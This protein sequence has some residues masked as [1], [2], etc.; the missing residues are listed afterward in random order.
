[1]VSIGCAGILVSDLFCGPMAALP[2]EGE[3]LAV[4]AMTISAGGCAANVAIDLALQGLSVDI[5]GCVGTDPSAAPLLAELERYGVGCG[6]VTRATELPTSKTVILVIEHEDRRYIHTFGANAAFGAGDL[7]ADWL[8]G[9]DIFYLGGLFALPAMDTSALAPLLHAAR[10]AGTRTVVDVVVPN[11]DAAGAALDPLLPQIDIFVPNADEARAFTGLDAPL[12]QIAALQ[13]R[14]AN[15]VIVTCGE[16]G[17]YAGAAGRYFHAPAYGLDTV[18]PSGSGDAFTAGIIAGI[19]QG[20]DLEGM[21]R[22]GAA[23]GAS[24]ARAMGTTT[25]VFR[26]GEAGAFIAANPIDVK[27]LPWKSR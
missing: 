27:E 26:G 1:M 16:G 15:T 21:L 9:L 12:E 14:G 22:L 10:A 18:D 25:S 24:A 8:T 5:A 23:L 7:D 19:A 20:L 11:S 2:R 4:P 3:L 6:R 17:A 13:A